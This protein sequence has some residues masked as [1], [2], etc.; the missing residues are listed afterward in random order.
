MLDFF[1]TRATATG[2]V[3]LTMRIRFARSLGGVEADLLADSLFERFVNFLFVVL[4][5]VSEEDLL[6]CLA[7]DGIFAKKKVKLKY[8]SLEKKRR[9][10]C[11]TMYV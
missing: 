11:K 6:G 2:V 9:K 8:F 5:V 1:T 7:L 3:F 10:I 4:F